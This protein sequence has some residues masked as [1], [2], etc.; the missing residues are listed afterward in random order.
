[1]DSFT[2]H[3]H[4][5]RPEPHSPRDL[6]LA[7]WRDSLA[8]AVNGPSGSRGATIAQA[9]GV[10]IRAETQPGDVLPPEELALQSDRLRQLLTQVDLA[11]VSAEAVSAALH[12]CEAI[13][14][15]SGG[16]SA[17]AI[18]RDVDHL[19]RFAAYLE[20]AG[21]RSAHGV[22]AKTDA[23]HAAER[24]C[25]A[26][27][28]VV[29]HYR[30]LS[31]A[32]VWVDALDDCTA[33]TV[34]SQEPRIAMEQWSALGDRRANVMPG[35]RA[36]RRT[37]YAIRQLRGCLHAFAVTA[38]AD[39]EDDSWFHEEDEAT[40]VGGLRESV[41]RWRIG[42]RV[43]DPDELQR[44]AK[45]HERDSDPT[46]AA[47]ARLTRLVSAPR[48]LAAASAQGPFRGVHVE[49]EA[50]GHPGEAARVAH[51][52]L[53]EGDPLARVRFFRDGNLDKSLDGLGVSWLGLTSTVRGGV[54]EFQLEDVRRLH[55]AELA[56]ALVDKLACLWVE[57]TIWSCTEMAC[58]PSGR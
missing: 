49:W 58:T 4:P 16:Q 13:E 28:R 38:D 50:P 25:R 52:T 26:V 17:D 30:D 15:R 19:A 48:A 21:A 45:E 23:A 40:L 22:D 5:Q 1:M 36:A 51:C 10:L 29:S 37:A 8:A 43:I 35:L 11:Q 3:S 27:E 41:A 32:R 9:F 39:L 55:L 7:E 44:L 54:V 24:C 6:L 57:R 14:H 20:W 33:E 53:N 12:Q 31:T 46:A 2:H 56:S 42:D 34:L 18:I 47:F